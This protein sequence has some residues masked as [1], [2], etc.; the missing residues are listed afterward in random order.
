MSDLLIKEIMS[1]VNRELGR[2]EMSFYATVISYDK[3][4][5]TADILPLLKYT[6]QTSPENKTQKNFQEMK[7][8][9]VDREP[10]IRPMYEAGDVVHCVA[11]AS[12]IEEPIENNR[13]SD[14]LQQRFDLSSCTIKGKVQSKTFAA[15]SHYSTESGLILNDDPNF[16]IAFTPLLNKIMG[17]TSII[18]NAIISGALSAATAVLG[19]MVIGSSGLKVN[20]DTRSLVTH[21]ELDAALQSLMT[22][23]NSALATKFDGAGTAG[24]LSVDITPAKTD[25]I[26]VGLG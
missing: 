11:A 22:A 2:V 17:N 23:L 15:P 26:K 9:R 18:G 19:P 12:A 24:S 16:Y 13:S 8:V 21:T 5:M 6:Q 14:I 3:E 10:G 20:G 4:A 1:A 7:G 25:N